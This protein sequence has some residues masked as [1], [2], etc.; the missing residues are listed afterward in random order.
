[1]M[2]RG[3]KESQYGKSTQKLSIDSMIGRKCYKELRKVIVG[4]RLSFV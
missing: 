1:M 3:C 4:V 2:I